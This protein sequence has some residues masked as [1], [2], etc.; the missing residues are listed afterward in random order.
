M[1]WTI[2]EFVNSSVW[3][4]AGTRL[5]LGH[6]R[7]AA[8]GEELEE[9]ATDLGGGQRHDPRIRGDGWGRHRPQWYRTERGPALQWDRD[10]A[11]R[12]T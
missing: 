3:S 7:V 11:V 1:N 2:P 12:R 9:A 4:P 5:A 6:D 8:L 10:V